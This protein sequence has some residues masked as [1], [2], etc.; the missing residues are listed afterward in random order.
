MVDI[1]IHIVPIYLEKNRFFICICGY[2]FGLGL[3]LLCLYP[4]LAAER[5]IFGYNYSY[6]LKSI[7]GDTEQNSNLYLCLLSVFNP[8]CDGWIRR[9]QT[10]VCQTTDT[11]VRDPVPPEGS[12]RSPLISSDHPL[13][14][15]WSELTILK[16]FAHRAQNRKTFLK[17]FSKISE[18]D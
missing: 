10:G 6:L 12:L 1:C 4:R 14:H 3:H 2:L 15:R 11:S 5:H 16:T 9:D 8:I 17:P 7:S 13:W 18:I